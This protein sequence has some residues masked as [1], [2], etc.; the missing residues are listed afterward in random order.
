MPGIYQEDY[1]FGFHQEIGKAEAE[2][3]IVVCGSDGSESEDEIED[4][5]RTLAS[6][7]NIISTH[8]HQMKMISPFPESPVRAIRP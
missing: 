5:Y 8:L 4:Q 1:N 2:D 6:V 7:H 3:Q